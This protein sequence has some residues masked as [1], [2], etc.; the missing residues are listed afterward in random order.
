MMIEAYKQTGFLVQGRVSKLETMKSRR[1]ADMTLSRAPRCVIEVT[2]SCTAGNEPLGT[3]PTL[4]APESEEQ[5]R[6][7]AQSGHGASDVKR[8]AG[9]AHDRS[10]DVVLVCFSNEHVTP[11]DQRS[12]VDRCTHHSK[13]GM[14]LLLQ[15]N[16]TNF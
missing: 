7:R 6:N 9:G 14:P 4:R 12:R 10:T 15:S 3:P 8:T 5:R 16:D 1:A 11:A 13:N 2:M